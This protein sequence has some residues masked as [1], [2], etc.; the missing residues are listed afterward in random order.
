[1]MGAV[2]ILS[3]IFFSMV[4]RCLASSVYQF[5]G[6]PSQGRR[7]RFSASTDAISGFIPCTSLRR[8]LRSFRR[9]CLVASSNTAIAFTRIS[10]FSLSTVTT[11]SVATAAAVGTESST[12][13]A[14]SSLCSSSSIISSPAISVN[15]A[16][17]SSSANCIRSSN[18]MLSSSV[19]CCCDKSTST[20][21]FSVWLVATKGVSS[22]STISE[23][24]TMDSALASDSPVSTDGPL[25]VVVSSNSTSAEDSNT[26][27]FST[28]SITSVSTPGE[29]SGST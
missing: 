21:V 14:F 6:I 9:I 24:S 17:P 10:S 2:T 20:G 25:I 12:I 15:A 27:S 3:M 29:S 1:M 23:C 8:Y 19:V 28:T 13:G 5:G 16:S 4:C 22:S 7:R 26:D 11:S 18:A